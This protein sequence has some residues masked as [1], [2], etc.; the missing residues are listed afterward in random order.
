MSGLGHV[1][2]MAS[3]NGWTKKLKEI[4]DRG[5]VVCAVTQCING[6]VD[7]L[8][9]SNGREILSTGVV[10]LE[11]MLAETAFVKLGYV[12]GKTKDKEEIKRLMLKNIAREFNKR[13]EE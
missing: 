11:D 8:V 9:Y 3:R 13:L 2:T 1:S 12:L 6:R 10:Y 4:I 7:P 5:M